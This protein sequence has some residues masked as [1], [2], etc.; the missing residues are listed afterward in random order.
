MKCGEVRPFLDSRYPDR[1]VLHAKL[2]V[3]LALDVLHALHVLHVL[4]VL[5]VL[6][7]LHVLNLLYVQLETVGFTVKIVPCLLTE[8][9]PNL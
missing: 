4:D 6:D 8:A 5:D 1:Q 9:G 2:Y 3:L 7:V